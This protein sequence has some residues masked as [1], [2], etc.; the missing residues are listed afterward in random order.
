MLD[1]F[2]LPTLFSYSLHLEFERL[3]KSEKPTW[4]LLRKLSSSHDGRAYV[5]SSSFDEGH[6]EGKGEVANI[7]RLKPSKMSVVAELPTLAG[8]L[9]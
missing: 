8:P 3:P 7:G 9:F 1:P 4:T 2:P 5:L 6:K